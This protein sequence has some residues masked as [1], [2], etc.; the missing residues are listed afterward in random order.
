[1]ARQREK[2]LAYSEI[3]D[4][5]LDEE[6]RRT[7]ATKIVEVVAHFLGT[8]RLDGLTF[9]DVGCSVGF[10][11]DAMRERG[12]NA[13][14]VD[15]DV[16][17][18]AAARERFGERILF[19]CAD[20]ERLPLP[21][22]SVDIIVFNHIYEHVVDPFKVMA[23]LRRVLKPGGLM[24]LGLANR[25][26]IVEPHYKLPFLSWLPYG[27]IAD[28]Y[29][30]AFGRAEFYHERFLTRGGLKRL[31]RGLYVTEYTYAVIASPERFNARDVVPK[32]FDK[33]PPAALTALQPIM[34]TFIWVATK[35]PA[36]PKGEPLRVPPRQ[37]RA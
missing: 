36:L 33:L 19:L 21:D 37:F 22:E 11:A 13:I 2:Q 25:L 14:G 12:A 15:I 18:L 31:C 4:Q 29:V 35:Q 32:A 28:R 30:R 24:Y 27:T 9:A 17:G 16:P 23:E 20:G 26:G 8:D 6:G 34:P 1:M 5:M 7:K 10:V 3:Q